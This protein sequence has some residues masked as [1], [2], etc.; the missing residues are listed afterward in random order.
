[1]KT[2]IILTKTI[3]VSQW[4]SSTGGVW[5]SAVNKSKKLQNCWS[6]LAV[7]SGVY[8]QNCKDTW[9]LQILLNAPVFIENEH[10]NKIHVGIHTA[11]FEL[12]VLGVEYVWSLS[13]LSGFRVLDKESSCVETGG[14]FSE[15]TLFMVLLCD[16][17]FFLR[18]QMNRIIQANSTAMTITHPT[19]RMI[20]P[21]VMEAIISIKSII[22]LLIWMEKNQE[23]TI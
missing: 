11:P 4:R 6:S 14:E 21:K 12:C 13:L 7:L 23:E 10:N 3:V 18:L 20:T 19:T 5:A 16:V 22:L 8:H 17:L 15:V 1:M 2:N 9:C